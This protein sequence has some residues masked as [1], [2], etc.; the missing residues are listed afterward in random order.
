[1]PY[2][3]I[4]ELME[5]WQKSVRPRSTNFHTRYNKSHSLVWIDMADFKALRN[6]ANQPS[7]IEPSQIFKR[8]PKPPTMNDLWDGQSKVLA[9]WFKR[10]KERDLVVKLNTGGGKTLVGLLIGQST[11][12]EIKEPVLYLCATRQLVNQTLEKA[13]EIGLKAVPY[14]S[15]K[16]FSS[17]FLDGEAVMI[18]TYSALF[19][20]LS[21]FGV[22]GDGKEPVKLGALICDDAHAAVATIRD[23]FTISIT[24]KDH[25]ELYSELAGQFRDD[26]AKLRRLGSFDDI[27]ERSDLGVLELPYTAWSKHHSYVRQHIA[28]EYGDRFRFQFPLLRDSFEI[29]HVLVSARDISITP[30]LPLINLFPSSEDCKRRI[31]MSATIADDSSLVRTFGTAPASARNP[32]APESLAGV[33]ERM[34][35]APSLMNI[36]KSEPA[37]EVKAVIKKVRRGTRVVVLVQSEARAKQWQD[38]GEIVKGDD[39]EIAV[40]ELLD[41]TANGPYVFPAR[42]DGIDLPNDACRVLVLDGLPAAANSFDLYRAEVLR[43]NS[44]INVGIAQKVEQGLGRATRGAGDYCVIFLTGNDLIAWITRT[45]SLALMTNST[46]TQIKMGHTISKSLKTRPKLFETVSQCLE[47]DPEWTSFHAETLA[48]ATEEEK[49]DAGAITVASA[50]RDALRFWLANDF[51]AAIGNLRAAANNQDSRMQGWLLQNA[52]RVAYFGGREEHSR[53][54]QKEAFFNN[55]LLFPPETAIEYQPISS[56]GEQ[57]SNIADNIKEFEFRKGARD[58]FEKTVSYLAPSS[59]SNQFEEALKNLGTLLGY[60]AQRPDHETGAGPDVLWLSGKQNAAVIECKHRKENRNPLNKD[61]HGQLLTSVQ[62]FDS[63]YPNRNSISFV[64][65]PTEEATEQAAADRTY[66]MSIAKLERMLVAANGL[67]SDLSLLTEVGSDLEKRCSELLVKYKLRYEDLPEYLSY[68]RA[69]KL[70]KGK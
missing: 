40:K 35:L 31:Y 68:F 6:S 34:I 22:L 69:V 14:T 63:R 49:V 13:S 29:C 42:Y 25:A 65:H 8:L 50:E 57:G 3:K 26:F 67:F 56:P 70:G 59:S 41:G 39:V 58:E 32:I 9:E 15:G 5:M 47:R 18:A 27:V 16:D 19:N 46:R 17:K 43:G 11:L 38:V 55:P 12:N 48:D 7:P 10:R 64:V 36:E 24:K 54:L 60:K 23:A 21:K 61:E 1:V 28:R 51:D 30:P 52:A 66:V 44:S 33:G 37:E 20:G 4:N 2:K 62:W 45:A 53:N